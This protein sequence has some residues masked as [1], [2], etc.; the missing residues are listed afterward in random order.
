[1]CMM[2]AP[3]R[4]LSPDIS[5]LMSRL[6]AGEAKA[7]EAL[8]DLFYDELR[9]F[10]AAKM[11]AERQNHTWQPTALVNELYLELLKIK[12][13]KEGAEGRAGSDRAAFF[14]LAG[15]VMHRLLLAH[16]RPVAYRVQ[17]VPLDPAQEES[18]SALKIAEM[19][20]LLARLGAVD[21]MLRL[22][23]ELKVF[24]GLTGDET[25]QR[26]GCSPRSVARYWNFAQAWL[27]EALL[28]AASEPSCPKY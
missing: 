10:A 25:A 23:A 1:M 17:R 24:E 8:V 28:P 19:E 20:A 15:H 21:P 18:C 5:V 27:S 9:R 14:S 26:L 22:V 3:E 16:V 11:R 12:G 13:L 7:A 4:A 6:R 2:P